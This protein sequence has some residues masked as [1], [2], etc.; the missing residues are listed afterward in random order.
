MNRLIPSLA[1]ACFSLAAV[2][3]FAQAPAGDAGKGP[4]MMGGGPRHGMM[5]PCSQES[6]PAKCEARRNEMREHMKTAREACK[7]SPDRRGCMTQQFCAKQADPAKCQERAKQ[8]HERMA[9][10][11]D[12]RQAAHE[13]CTGKRGDELMKCLHD[14]PG[15]KMQHRG[16]HHDHKPGKQG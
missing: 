10:R 2:T 7:D 1:A 9:K 14:Q 8:M 11:M 6:D 5:K 3:A 12:E 13:A 15:M 16:P 4:G